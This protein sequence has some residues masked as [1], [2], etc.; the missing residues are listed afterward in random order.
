MK[1][2]K[3]LVEE[4]LLTLRENY[5]LIKVDDVK[6]TDSPESFIERF[7]GKTLR[8]LLDAS[9]YARLYSMNK[10]PIGS[11]PDE[12]DIHD[13]IANVLTSAS[14]FI[15]F[16]K[17]DQ[18]KD[19][20]NKSEEEL[21][22]DSEY[23][24]FSKE[25]NQLYRNKLTAT[26]DYG[27]D[28]KEAEEANQKIIDFNKSGKLDRIPAYIKYRKNVNDFENMVELIHNT[29]LSLKDV[30]P[31]NNDS[32]VD[33]ERWE[34]FEKNFAKLK[35][36]MGSDDMTEESKNKIQ[37]DIEDLE[38]LLNNPDPSRIKD[39]GSEESY[40]KMLKAKIMALKVKL[41]SL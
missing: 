15:N 14:Y 7:V 13:L 40:K 41:K 39:Y 5:D 26:R 36:I 1:L 12:N 29:K 10:R 4:C 37:N 9:S 25:R 24:T 8:E 18:L 11:N 31:S 38:M 22:N 16:R 21:H 34:S 30:L 27:S 3:K 17:L 32:D 19:A 28:S 33:K 6:F 35:K 20:K 23:R 2:L